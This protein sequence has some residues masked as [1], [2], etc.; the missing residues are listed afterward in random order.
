MV[1]MKIEDDD[2]IDFYTVT[3]FAKK[4]RI[5]YNTVLK[6]IKSGRISACKVGNARKSG[7]R[8]PKSEIERMFRFDMEKMI[9]KIVDERMKGK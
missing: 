2:L 6:S 3:E 7:Y 8:I 5:H 9:E 4:L 1:C